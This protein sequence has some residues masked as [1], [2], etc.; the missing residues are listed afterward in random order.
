MEPEPKPVPDSDL[1]PAV[2]GMTEREEA[3][4]KAAREVLSKLAECMHE[5]Y[6]G[7]DESCAKCRLRVAVR[8]YDA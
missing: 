2:P 6:A 5:V 4:L 8:A 3:L 1:E 7:E